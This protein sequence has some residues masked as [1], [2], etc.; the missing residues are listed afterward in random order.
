V[1]YCAIPIQLT[2]R[3]KAG[4]IDSIFLLNAFLALGRNRFPDKTMPTAVDGSARES[5]RGL[6]MSFRDLRG[7]SVEAS[8]VHFQRNMNG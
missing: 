2:G 1:S 5:D 4:T 8:L 3:K 7:F 6:L